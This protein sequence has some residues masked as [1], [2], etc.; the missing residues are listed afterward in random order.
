M[1]N[2]ITVIFAK[3]NQGDQVKEEEMVRTCSTNGEKRNRYRI[4]ME[5]AAVNRPL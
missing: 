2:F 3:F 4:L 5:K 1:G